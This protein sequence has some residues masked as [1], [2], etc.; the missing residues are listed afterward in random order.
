[1]R[2]RHR[3]TPDVGTVSES[4]EALESAMVV[5]SPGG[6][7]SRWPSLEQAGADEAT[8]QLVDD[9]RRFA[10]DRARWHEQCRTRDGGPADDLVVRGRALV[11]EAGHLSEA[12]A[13]VERRWA[14]GA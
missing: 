13:A 1:M 10:A 6:A 9:Y 11:A 3:V 7:R 2:I 14:V 5:R 12:A 4:L 8:V